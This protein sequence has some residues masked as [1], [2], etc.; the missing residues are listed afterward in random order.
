M[1]KAAH[2]FRQLGQFILQLSIGEES[3]G[4]AA[5]WLA[6]GGL[7]QRLQEAD[8]ETE[9]WAHLLAAETALSSC[10]FLYLLNFL[11]RRSV[12][13]VDQQRAREFAETLTRWLGEDAEDAAPTAPIW[14]EILVCINH[15]PRPEDETYHYFPTQ[16]EPD[17]A[18]GFKVLGAESGAN[19]SEWQR[20]WAN[21]SYRQL[22][23]DGAG[24][25]NKRK[26]Y[27]LTLAKEAV[28]AA[29]QILKVNGDVS[30]ILGRT[31]GED[32]LL[33]KIDNDHFVQ[34]IIPLVERLN[35]KPYNGWRPPFSATPLYL[36][37]RLIDQAVEIVRAG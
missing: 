32:R 28:A 31:F 18:F 14:P 30:V 8:D 20:G 17:L 29:L 36:P 21:S 12:D 27:R 13:F 37:L 2:F 22:V 24:T 3:R 1:I 19:L 10:A 26:Y 15:W 4:V 5:A 35:E 25:R 6:E 33:V 11:G 9:G 16:E 34:K 23:I 7:V